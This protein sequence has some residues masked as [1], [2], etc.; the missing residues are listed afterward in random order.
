MALL[1]CGCAGE[2]SE[3]EIMRYVFSSLREFSRGDACEVLKAMTALYEKCEWESKKADFSD[4]AREIV[5]LDIATRVW[6][7]AES[8]GDK[9]VEEEYRLKSLEW[10]RSA[11]V[12]DPESSDEDYEHALNAR[13]SQILRDESP[14]WYG[15]R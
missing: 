11:D 1:C 12:L 15:S 10:L 9:I 7:A 6:I 14:A 13:R 5:L 4:Y 8:C 2:K 3:A